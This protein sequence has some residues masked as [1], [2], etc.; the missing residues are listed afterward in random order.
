MIALFFALLIAGVAWL[1]YSIY[2]TTRKRVH[3]N[4]ERREYLDEKRAFKHDIE[5][6]RSRRKWGRK[7]A[8]LNA[9]RADRNVARE[10]AS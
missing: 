6:A 9:K 7:L 8:K 2:A 3:R 5:R 4:P 10:D 1:A